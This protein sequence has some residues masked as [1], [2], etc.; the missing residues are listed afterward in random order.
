MYSPT[1]NRYSFYVN[2]LS[3]LLLSYLELCPLKDVIKYQ[4][5]RLS[6]SQFVYTFYLLIYL[7]FIHLYYLSI[8][9]MCFLYLFIYL[10][11][12]VFIILYYLFI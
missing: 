3:S 12:C 4:F 5:I 7:S 11:I 6:I 9:F 8:N 2:C 10:F 1:T